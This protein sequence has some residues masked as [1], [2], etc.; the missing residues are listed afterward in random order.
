MAD[1]SSV[2]TSTAVDRKT[3]AASSLWLPQPKWARDE[4]NNLIGAES[5]QLI[6]GFFSTEYVTLQRFPAT[7]HRNGNV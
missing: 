4:A 1:S 7:A 2:T 3:W 6:P 5:L